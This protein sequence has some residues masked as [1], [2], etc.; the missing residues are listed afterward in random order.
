MK[1][2][3]VKIGIFLALVGVIFLLDRQFGWTE[4]L[5][6]QQFRDLLADTVSG[7]LPLAVGLYTAVTVVACVV[8]AL[9]GAVFALLAGVLFGPWL[10]TLV[11]L[12]ATTIGAAL[13]FLVGRFFLK[14]GIKPMLERNKALKK[15]LF[16][17]DRRSHLVLLMV[18]RMVPLFPYN[19][20]NFAYGIT[21]VG[22]VAYTLYT[23]VFMLPGVAFFTIGAAGLTA[24]EERWKYFLLAAVLAAVVTGAG[25]W[26]KKKFLDKKREAILLFTRVPVPGATK[27]RL[28]P[29][30]S[31]EE[32]AALH[33]RFIR[34]IYDTCRRAG[35]DV[36]VFYTPEDQEGIFGE[37]LPGQRLIPQRGDGLGER[38]KL[39][40]DHAFA[41][42]YTA[43]VLIGTDIP[44]IDT[45][46]L[47]NAFARLEE[48]DVVLGP[49]EDGGYY[50]IGMKEAYGE[51]WN[52]PRYGTNTVLE[53]TLA[54][55]R[56]AGLTVRL[57]E[58]LRDIDTPED[59]LA[60][61]GGFQ[62]PTDCVHCGRCTRRCVF[63]QKYGL[64]LAGLAEKPE[65]AYHCFLCGA[66]AAVCPKG[67][68][69][70]AIALELRRERVR[71]D[72]GKLR[73]SAYRALLLEKDPYLFANYRGGKTESALFMGCNFPAF[74]PRTAEHLTELLAQRGIGVIYDCCGKPVD[75]LG[76]ADHAGENIRAIDKRCRELGVKELVL[77][78]PNCY[79]YLEGKLEARLVTVYEK[80]AEL[81]LGKPI[82]KAELPMYYPCPDRRERRMLETASPF[83]PG[84]E[85]NAYPDLQCCGLGGCASCKEKKLAGQLAGQ[86][87]G[88]GRELYTY[89]A[90]CVSNFR[91]SG[92]GGAYHILPLIL[93]VEEEP[94]L[95]IAPLLHRMSHKFK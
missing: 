77:V 66:C 13:S 84:G 24:G 50:L 61:C 35:P 79:A 88:E 65:L 51:I 47:Q 39:A 74:F 60:V 6:G 58:T 3:T 43:C 15:L 81:G 87:V 29:Y 11:C 85:R 22:F 57:G 9:P 1:K 25:L 26:I 17:E 52:V 10:G 54:H 71:A 32:C 62:R 49:T 40:F 4:A 45:E 94:P 64:D 70:R 91:R 18:T 41:Q 80:L 83:L 8:L 46:I 55:I 31:G 69:G 53:D 48:S 36:L 68:D 30:L 89:C 76:L 42:G 82:E 14:D 86:A 38:M 5:S 20:Q 21:D 19:L 95:G 75:E 23:F 56:A 2:S 73:D 44:Q 28:M 63:L 33:A 78:C 27:T 7:D 92:C 72:G 37:L 90:S 59:L 67:L 12:G 34:T 93:G 16:S